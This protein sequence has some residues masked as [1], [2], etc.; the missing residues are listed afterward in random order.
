MDRDLVAIGGFVLLFVLMALRVP[1]GIAMGIVGVGGF[2]LMTNWTAAFG[3]LSQSPFSTVTSFNLSIIPMFVLMGTFAARAGMSR[4]IFAA[5]SAWIGHRRGGLAIA[6]ILACGGFASIS[7]SAVA[8]AATMTR[9]ALPELRREG[10]S[11]RFAT[12]VIAAG[13]T[14][15]I[16][17]PPSLMFVLYSLMTDVDLAKLFMA[18]LLPG[19][20]GMLMYMGTILTVRSEDMPTGRLHSWH[21]RLT[22]LRGV[23][24]AL[25]LFTCVIG[26]MY[27]GVFTVTEASAVGAVGALLLGVIQGRLD[28]AAIMECLQN[29]LRTTAAIFMIVI[30]AYLFGYF[31]TVTQVTQQ[32]IEFLVGLPVGPYGVLALILGV[33]F[34]L[35]ALMDELAMILITVPIVF[36]AMTQL[37]FDP[38]WFGV[39]IVMTC[40]LGLI[41]PPVGMNVFVVNSLAPDVKLSTIYRG[42]MPFIVCDLIRLLLLC[43]FPGIAL[44]LPGLM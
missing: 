24:P 1:V 25:T 44:L 33:Y 29:A 3:L 34:I 43:I 8:T 39:I 2:G 41:C 27:G 31:L 23:W 36:P 30:G 26:G 18:G 13:G 19:I 9:V 5:S 15:G 11:P 12:G 7:G 37:G 6:T 17:V 20:L 32:I 28:W 4:D 40:V 42:V 38:V 10:Y 16:M 21:E 35:G 14:L 22:T